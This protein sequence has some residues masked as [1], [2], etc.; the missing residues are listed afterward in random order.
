[1]AGHAGDIEVV[2]LPVGEDGE[3]GEALE[4]P[5]DERRRRR[6]VAALVAATVVVVTLAAPVARGRP[7][8]EAASPGMPATEPSRCPG[9][10][11]RRLWCAFVSDGACCPPGGG[12]QDPPAREA[13]D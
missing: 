11:T 13:V 8:Q 7:E 9:P 3:D 2:V 5:P 12:Q 4:R 1:M 10:D 6:R